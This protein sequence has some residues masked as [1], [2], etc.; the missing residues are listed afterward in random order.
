MA[1]FTNI[2]S[3]GT[4]G[5][6]GHH[7]ATV[8]AHGRVSFDEHEKFALPVIDDTRSAAAAHSIHGQAAG[9]CSIRLHQ[10]HRS[11]AFATARAVVGG[12][13]TSA[14]SLVGSVLLAGQASCDGLSGFLN[15][16][17]NRCSGQVDRFGVTIDVEQ[18]PLTRS[19]S[20]RPGLGSSSHWRSATTASEKRVFDAVS[21]ST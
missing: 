20:G 11:I 17:F 15:G 18:P 12:G 13:G 4:R 21:S 14:T 2:C 7:S 6:D 8:L 19:I 1:R 9:F 5:E 16:L 10:A 3:R